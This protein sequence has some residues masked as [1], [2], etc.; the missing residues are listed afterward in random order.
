MNMHELKENMPVH[1]EAPGTKVRSLKGLGGMY[2]AYAEIPAGA[3]FT[4]LLQGLPNDKC[5]CPH[6]G[7]VLSGS[8]NL[9]YADGSEEVVKAGEVFYWPPGHTAWTEEETTFIEFSPEK[10]FEEVWE[11]IKK[12]ITEM[13]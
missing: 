7:Y 3:D 10:E 5:H 4:P 13:G 9:R 6:W 12:K 11:N 8:I 2:T 1:F